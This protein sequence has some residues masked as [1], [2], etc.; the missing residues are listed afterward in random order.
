MVKMTRPK[1]NR[2]EPKHHNKPTRYTDIYRTRY[3]TAAKYAFFSRANGKF[4]KIDH[5]LGH[6]LTLNRLFK[7]GEGGK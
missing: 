4:S 7:G 2:R 5:L 3:P 6:K 1:I